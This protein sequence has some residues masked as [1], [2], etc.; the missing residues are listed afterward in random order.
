MMNWNLVSVETTEET[1]DL[2]SY[3]L[4]DAGATGVEIEGGSTLPQQFDELKAPVEDTDIVLVKAYYGT[5]GFQD[6]LFD[7]KSRL[8]SLKNETDTDT[9]TLNVYVNTV[10]DTDWNENFKKNFTTFK[11]AGRIVIKPSWEEYKPEGD[12]LVLEIDPGMAFGSG[13]HETT[14]MCL[15]LIQKY[16]PG[17]ARALDVG[18]GS[19]ILGIACSKLGAEKVVSLDFDGVCVKVTEEN[20]RNNGVL[21]LVSIK[22]DLLQNAVK[23]KYDVII[24]NIVAD[25]I[26]R[27][28]ENVMEFM[29]PDSVYIISGI[30][31]E[32]LE[33]VIKSL[34]ENGFAPV[35]ILSMADWRALAVKIKD[36]T[37]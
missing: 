17:N 29:K 34:D 32:R 7:I 24:A 5:D 33:D 12:E 14:K 2:V 1:S 36:K 18:C 16:M 3:I 11:A 28:N 27:L 13:A 19:G 22:S 4:T 8:K 35:E 30:I 20:A 37:V 15:E 21:N 31:E 25:I 26:I 9:G 23:D 10:K 6:I